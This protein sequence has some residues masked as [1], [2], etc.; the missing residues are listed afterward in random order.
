MNAETKAKLIS[1]TTKTDDA[2]DGWWMRA[3]VAAGEHVEH[4]FHVGGAGLR[5]A[6]AAALQ[7]L[8]QD[9]AHVRCTKPH[10]GYCQSVH[11]GVDLRATLAVH[12]ALLAEGKR[13]VQQPHLVLTV[14]IAV[15]LVQS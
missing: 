14:V 3:V 10:G 12:R 7:G 11:H 6:L 1:T 8:E 13:R 15:I 4:G 5:G 9:V 2:W